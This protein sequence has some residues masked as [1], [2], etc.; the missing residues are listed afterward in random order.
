MNAVLN[1]MSL[2][3]AKAL[4]L[5]VGIALVLLAG[6]CGKP[7]ARQE[8]LRPSQVHDFAVLFA[9]NCSGCH[10]AEGKLGPAPPLNDPMFLTIA[11]PDELRQVI[12]AGR[13]GTMMPAFAR[14]QGG[15]LTPQQVDV[16]I[17][18]LQRWKQEV[19]DAS[20][21]PTYLAQSE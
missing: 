1:V 18:G 8:A 6:G 13:H 17:D 15:M 4:G 11:P 16:L 20:E 2:A 3:N 19:S 14:E 9:Q 7:T 10:G 21:L 12:S 5:M